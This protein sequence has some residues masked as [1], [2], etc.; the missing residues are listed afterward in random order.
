MKLK[1]TNLTNLKEFPK[2]TK[3]LTGTTIT[4]IKDIVSDFGLKHLKDQGV[5]TNTELFYNNFIVPTDSRTMISLEDSFSSA[6]VRSRL[7]HLADDVLAVSP[8]IKSYLDYDQ[9]L[10][11]LVEDE[12]LTPIVVDED[13]TKYLILFNLRHVTVDPKVVNKIYVEARETDYAELDKD[14]YNKVAQEISKEYDEIR[15]QAEHSLLFL[16][17]SK[18]YDKKNAVFSQDSRDHLILLEQLSELKSIFG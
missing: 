9:A 15:P 12:T 17:E 2:L 13:D 3:A 6:L 8:N 7:H 4:P 1:K 14:A 16:N 5:D 10:S 18:D 11:S